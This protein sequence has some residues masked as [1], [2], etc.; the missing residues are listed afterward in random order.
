MS[1]TYGTPIDIYL[2][3]QRIEIRCYNTY[4]AYG[5]EINC[6][7]F[8]RLQFN[9]LFGGYG[10]ETGDGTK[11]DKIFSFICWVGF[12]CYFSNLI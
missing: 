9:L 1:R 11:N 6:L 3:F 2:I 4:R 7:K 5:S 10:G 8:L 12:H